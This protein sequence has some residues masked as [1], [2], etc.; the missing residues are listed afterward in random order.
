MI[1]ILA[2]C[3]AGVN[4]SHQIKEAIEA[5]MAERGYSVHCDAVMVKDIT[6]EMVSKYDIFTP[7][8]KTDLG[9]DMPIPTV[10][11]GPILYRI[12]AMSEPVFVKLEQVIK[13]KGLN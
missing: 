10:E 7:I 13:D 3:G 5:Q 12:P 4:S 8:A 6:E 11:A 1:K 9:F 2:A